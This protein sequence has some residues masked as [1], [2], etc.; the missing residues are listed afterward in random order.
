M[1]GILHEN[2][3]SVQKRQH[4]SVRNEKFK[5]H[6]IMGGNNNKKPIF[7]LIEK[8]KHA[9]NDTDCSDFLAA[10]DWLTLNY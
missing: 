5:L 3:A 8:S 7:L 10:V 1:L 9:R 6:D 4:I 2:C